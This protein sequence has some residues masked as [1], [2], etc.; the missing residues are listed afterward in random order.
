MQQIYLDNGSTSFPKAPGVGDAMKQ[1]IE[2]E[3]VNIARGTY[4]AAYGVAERI[5]SLREQ[6]AQLFGFDQPRNV[7]FSSGVT[8]SLNC[9]LK[10]LLRPGDEVLTSSM[11]HN[12]VLRPLLQLQNSGVVVRRAPCAEDGSL[13]LARFAELLST[14]TRLVVMTHA[15]NVCGTVLPL[16]EIGALCQERGVFF[17]VDS[18][19]TAGVLPIDMA[20]MQIDALAFTGHK[21]LLGPPGTGGMLLSDA[22]AAE[23]QPLLAG[24]TGSRSHLEEMPDFLPDKF[25]AGTANLPGLLGLAKAV[26]FLTAKGVAAIGRHELE[27]AMQLIRGLAGLPG[28]RVVGR[29][30]ATQRIGVVSVD[31]CQADNAEMAFRLESEQGILTRCGL[32]CA[33]AAHQT[34]GTYP[35]GTVRFV[36]GYA[37]TSAEIERAIAAIAAVSGS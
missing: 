37:T 11:E 16:A 13:D 8:A 34:L 29:T 33:P 3:G 6:L 5:L 14:R 25:E 21:G 15:S 10:G 1:Y 7:V 17:A 32:H 30:D 22:I 36:P 19:Q 18:A 20:E 9:I 2:Q 24:G 23:M 35:Q 12:A 31:F 26:E 28:L 4:A 27:L